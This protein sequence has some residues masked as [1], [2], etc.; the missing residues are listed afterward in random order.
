MKEQ[1]DESRRK[2]LIRLSI[3]MGAIPAA[4]VAVPILGALFGPLLQRQKQEWR[5]VAGLDEIR[6][7]DTKL[8][9]YMDDNPLPWAGV[10]AK[11]AAW[12][13]RISQDKFEAFAANCSHLGCPVR[14]EAKA[15]LFMCP[16]HGGVYNKDGTVASGPPPRALTKLQVRINNKDIEIMTAPIPITPMSA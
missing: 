4:L 8:V 5:R 9:T 7:G 6:I 12:L 11:S 1:I 16:C 13:R 3:I 10:T 14:W 2:F 15:E